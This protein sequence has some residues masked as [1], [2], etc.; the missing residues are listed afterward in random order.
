MIYWFLLFSYLVPSCITNLLWNKLGTFFFSSILSAHKTIH[1][2]D[3]RNETSIL[4]SVFS[5]QTPECYMISGARE[6]GF[7]PYPLPRHQWLSLLRNTASNTGSLRSSLILI[8]IP[9]LFPC[10]LPVF[11]SV[12]ST[13]VSSALPVVH[14]W[15]ALG[16]VWVAGHKCTHT[17]RLWQPVSQ[18]SISLPFSTLR[19]HRPSAVGE[20]WA[21]Y[22]VLLLSAHQ[23]PVAGKILFILNQWNSWTGWKSGN[24]T[25]QISKTLLQKSLVIVHYMLLTDG[26]F[27]RSQIL[28][29]GSSWVFIPE[30]RMIFSFLL[31]LCSF[32]LPPSLWL[33]PF[34]AL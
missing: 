25:S 21:Q 11:F 4:H 24:L 9:L 19:Q 2:K 23:T 1:S 20:G 15:R 26:F 18:H 10:P 32:S 27:P 34:L 33:L 7:V 5:C 3:L 16:K 31:E 14:P 28:L 22:P 29:A 12:A 8:F 13:V 6:L 30:K 17:C